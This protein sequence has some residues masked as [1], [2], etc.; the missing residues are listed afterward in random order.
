MAT[1]R[2]EQYGLHLWEPGDDF[3]REEFN[4]NF[5]RLDLSARVVSGSYTG[6]GAA[7]QHIE[8]GFWP[9]SVL[10]AREDG[11]I[12]VS[13]SR[14]GY[15]GLALRDRPVKLSVNDQDTVVAV[16]PSGFTVFSRES[17]N[18][19]P[20]GNQSGVRYHFLAVQG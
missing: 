9:A 8:L 3:L 12:T 18:Q 5:S 4:E 11:E 2:T 15:G 20:R 14:T 6:N 7:G 19:S 17:S 1:N 10:A 16:D 13:L